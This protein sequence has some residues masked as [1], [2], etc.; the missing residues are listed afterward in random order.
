VAV[1]L[2]GFQSS[3]ADDTAKVISRIGS[4]WFCG[5]YRIAK[6]IAMVAASKNASEY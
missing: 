2:K 5:G 4:G 6:G 1:V 3:I